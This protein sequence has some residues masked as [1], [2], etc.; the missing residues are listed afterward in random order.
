M[1]YSEKHRDV[2]PVFLIRR[3]ESRIAENNLVAYSP[4]VFCVLLLKT[5]THCSE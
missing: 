3:I 1:K 5:G 4:S 2:I